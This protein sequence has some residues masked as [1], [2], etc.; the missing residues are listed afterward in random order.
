MCN[1]VE[2]TGGHLFNLALLIKQT[3][4]CTLQNKIA[5]VRGRPH[6]T[7]FQSEREPIS[8][9]SG[10]STDST[11]ASSFL[12]TRSSWGSKRSGLHLPEG[13]FGDRTMSPD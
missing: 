1:R 5:F 6:H 10:S 8:D 11:I 4:F 3:S 7:S 13:H 9:V 2:R 12:F